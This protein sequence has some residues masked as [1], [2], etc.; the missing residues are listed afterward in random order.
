MT[1]QWR[2]QQCHRQTQGLLDTFYDELQRHPTILASVSKLKGAIENEFD[3]NSCRRYTR[4]ARLGQSGALRLARE[5]SGLQLA[6]S[7]IYYQRQRKADV[8]TKTD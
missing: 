2:I 8:Q 3:L 4:N 7:L 1:F 5:K 6:K